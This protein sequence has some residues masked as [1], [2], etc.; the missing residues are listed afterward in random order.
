MPTPTFTGSSYQI[1]PAIGGQ[2][3]AAVTALDDGR[4]VAI[5]RSSS[6]AE[7]SLAFVIY[8]ADGTIS[9]TETIA[10][11]NDEGIIDHGNLN[12]AALK[13]GG[14]AIV[15]STR[16]G[17]GENVYHRVY[18]ADGN[19]LGEPVHTN[20]DVPPEALAKRPDIA[21]DGQGGFYV[22]WDDN[23]YDNDPGPGVTRTYVPRIQH[24]GADGQPL[25][26]PTRLGDDWG[27]DSNAAIAINRDGTRINV[28]WDDNLSGTGS[29][30]T[31]G[32]KGYE[33][34]GLGDYRADEGTY[35]EF[36]GTPDVAYSTGN[37]FMTVWSE[38]VSSGAYEIR[39]SIN[40]GPEFK[41]NTSAHQHWTTMPQVV[42]LKSG[43]FLVVWYDGGFDG[44]DDVL[45]QLFSATGEKIGDEFQISDQTST[46]ISRVEASEMLDGRVVVTWDSAGNGYKLLSRMVDVRQGAENWVGTDK[47][48]YYVGTA[49]ADTLDGGGGNDTLHGIGGADSLIG[50]SGN[51]T[52]AYSYATGGLT[53]SLTNSALNTGDAMGDTFNSIENLAG[54]T[55]ADRLAGNGGANWLYG[56]AGND[57]IESNAGKD[58]LLGGGGTDKLY[59]G[60]SADSF[61]FATGDTATS[62]KAADTIYDFSNAQGDLID[63]SDIDARSATTSDDKFSFIGSKAFS[64]KAGQLRVVNERSDTWVMGDTNGDGKA[65]FMI[66][67]DDAVTFRASSFDL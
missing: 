41:V 36:H 18:G 30:D 42:G 20:A 32:I 38:F 59:G 3:A 58:V 47:D 13:G 46:D 10:N 14:F 8:N 34:G 2:N 29:N 19:A 4:Y 45:G 57:T 6:L 27:A 60:A 39:G 51:D 12:I 33:F 35:H 67:L 7:G 44:N 23:G 1:G 17:A 63:L 11:P 15:W 52:V 61:V 9:K 16:A 48:E 22:V 64:E 26:L 62:K 54:S 66:H 43:N 55:F 49:L 53:V 21:G 24:F 37:N 56:L 25:D 65:D 5:Y 28:V 31:D 50:G 40:D